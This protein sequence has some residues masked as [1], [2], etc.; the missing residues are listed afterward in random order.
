M[1][2]IGKKILTGT[3]AA[4]FLLGGGLLASQVFAATDAV[5]QHDNG[6]AKHARFS[7]HAK[8]PDFGFRG[9]NNFFQEAATLLGIDQKSLMGELKQG[10]SLAEIAQE[11]AGL[12]KDEFLQK[13]L[14]AEN[15]KIDAAVNSGKMS[16]DQADK[17]KSSLT[18]RLKQMIENQHNKQTGGKHKGGF[19]FGHFGNPANLAQILGI[20]QEELTSNLQAGKSLAEIAQEKG[21]SEDQLIS[22]LKESMTDQLKSFVENKKIPHNRQPKSE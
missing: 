4:T 14:T 7:N 8:H 11:K 6:Y 12:S 5:T 1:K 9:G 2:P 15:E 22:K 20:T 3:L 17:F 10:K 21:I 18:D 19:K 13:L 16:Q